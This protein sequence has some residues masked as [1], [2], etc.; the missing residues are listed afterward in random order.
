MPPNPHAATGPTAYSAVVMPA[1]GPVAR[2]R[3][4]AR[5]S[6]A[7]GAGERNI[8]PPGTTGVGQVPD[9]ADGAALCGS[10]RARRVICGAAAG[11]CGPSSERAEQR[12]RQTG[13]DGHDAD[14]DEG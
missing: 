1:S 7:D 9:T 14:Q 5:W 8:G 3:A 13:D 11:S 6:R 4:R 12:S 10:G 2:S